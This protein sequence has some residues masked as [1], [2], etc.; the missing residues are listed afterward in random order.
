[1][2]EVHL[3][4]RV[5]FTRTVDYE[6]YV[7]VGVGEKGTVTETVW[8]DGYSDGPSITVKLDKAR[9]S[10]SEWDNTVKLVGPDLEAMKA[11]PIA[12]QSWQSKLAAAFLAGMVMTG[13]AEVAAA[14]MEG[15]P[16]TFV[17]AAEEWFGQ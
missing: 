16:S 6:P 8:D 5:V 17:T 1:M 4:Q 13:V 7:T 14:D 15:I 11:V 9:R 3:G 10:L 2:T 12:K